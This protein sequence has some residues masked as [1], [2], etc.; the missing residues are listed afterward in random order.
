MIRSLKIDYICYK[1]GKQWRSSCEAHSVAGKMDKEKIKELEKDFA[2]ALDV[3]K[4]CILSWYD[5]KVRR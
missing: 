4:V 3:D 1:D 2:K 5:L